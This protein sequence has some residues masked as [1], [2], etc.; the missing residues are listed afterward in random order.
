MAYLIRVALAIALAVAWWQPAG[1]AATPSG[2][3]AIAAV[4]LAV[5]IVAVLSQACWP[6]AAITAGPLLRRA[7]ALR[8]K[9]WSA[10]FQRQRNPD[11]AGRTRP[12]APTAAPAAA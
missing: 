4:A 3:L 2:L 8:R 5:A 10:A 11:A 7:I 6:G 9:S 1:H 12:R